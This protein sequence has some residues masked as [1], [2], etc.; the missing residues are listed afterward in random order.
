M[1]YPVS[2]SAIEQA[3]VSACRL[4]VQ[5]LKPGNVHVYRE[6][7][8]MTVADFEKSAEASA[9]HIS[10]TELITGERICAAVEATFASVGCNTNLGIILL[11][12]PLA[13]AAGPRAT[14]R[15]LDAR[16]QLVLDSLDT[17]DAKA[18]FRA[19]QGANPAGLGQV[20]EADVAAPAPDHLSLL[21]AMRMASERDLV[22]AQYATHYAI[23][24]NAA[25]HFEEEQAKG[26]S[27]EA[28]LGKVFVH[29]LGTL[30]DTHVARKHG[31][32]RAKEVQRR[33][34]E[35]LARWPLFDDPTA[36]GIFEELLA[37]DAE[38][39]AEGLNPGALADIMA[40]AAFYS[41]LKQAAR[42][43]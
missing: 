25:R 5:A 41:F 33:A 34:G 42:E 37:F 30:L 8:G 17:R 27:P 10:N 12:A 13:V 3:Y 22:A 7:H 2:R 40:A 32:A 26:L 1:T 31:V 9:P 38:L 21:E 24:R 23:V 20:P 43:S 16:L 35:I 36:P 19:I 29:L 14:G 28:A 18:A 15:T 6:G 39:K 11:A 4:E